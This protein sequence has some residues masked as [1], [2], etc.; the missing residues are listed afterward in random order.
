M[1]ALFMKIRKN[2]LSNPLVATRETLQSDWLSHCTL[3][4]II[5]DEWLAVVNKM[6]TFP[7]FSEILKE[8]SEIRTILET[9]ERAYTTA[10]WQF[11][12]RDFSKKF[13]T[14]TR[15]N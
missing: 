4:V 7:R 8:V 5:S 6:A 9:D 14:K 11:S 1:Y 15:N 12:P 2:V 3:S 13:S 10:V